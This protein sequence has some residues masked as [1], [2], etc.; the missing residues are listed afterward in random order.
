LLWTLA[1][2]CLASPRPALAQAGATAPAADS[3]DPD[4]T[5]VSFLPVAD[6]RVEEAH[7]DTNFG[8]STRLGTDGDA[9]YQ[10]ESALT[11]DVSGLASVVQSATLWLYVTSDGTADGPSVY[12]VSDNWSESGVTWTSRP[13]PTG[14]AASRMGAGAPNGWVELDVTSLIRGNGPVSLLLAQSSTDGA[15]YYSRQGTYKPMLVV[16][17]AD[18]V[19]LAAGDIACRPGQAVTATQCQQ[20]STSDLL[21]GSSSRSRVLAL[22]DEQYETGAYADFMAPGAYDS[23]W[24]RVKPITMPI[25]GNHEYDTPGA[26]GYYE[27][28]GSAAGDPT[29]GYYSFDLGAW[30]L[31]ALNSEIAASTG[32]AQETWLRSDL[33]G[34]TQPCIL[35]YWHQPRYTS[36]SVHKPDIYVT[37]LWQDLYAAGADLVLSGHNHN[38]ERFA[39]QDAAG[40]ADP[41][42][43]RQFV[44]GTGGESLY[45]FGTIQPN[46]EVHD[47]STFGVLALALRGSGYEWR[48]VPQAGGTFSDAGSAS[49]HD[50]A[51]AA[52]LAASPSV[53]RAP[54]AVTVD[55][56]AS[57]DTDRTPIAS[58]RFDFGDGSAPVGPQPD[59]TAAHTYTV[60]GSYTVTVT[61]ADRAGLV[62]RAS[63]P[64]VV[65][66]SNLVPNPGFETDLSGWN[67][68]G[69]GPG[70]ALTRAA[71]GHS[72]G[73]A[74]QLANTG[75]LPSTCGLNDSPNVVATT[76]AAPYTATLWV[77]ADTPGATLK[78]RWR[79]WSGGLLA[80]AATTLATLT[81]DWQPVSVTYSPTLPGASTLDLNAYVVG[82]APGTCFYGDDVSVTAP[83]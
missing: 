23:T 61:V 29:K 9:G 25:P 30:H 52:S 54:L 48:F 33:A 53:G 63:A 21:M 45:G 14:A 1:L 67:T 71:G 8:A 27:Y 70:I 41:R 38:Y 47:G 65:K 77:R 62:T 80:G 64:V 49:G 6:A 66:P 50:S 79:E 69:S 73:W 46:S 5:T 59:A 57:T 20:Q 22:G 37:P 17:S 55:A 7:P 56:S 18:P 76:S 26:A 10:I 60:P 82:A 34:T 13:Q 35:A 19:V 68:S 44:V 15:I 81:S 4:Q 32:S 43:I 74:A 24:G 28:F 3:V 11:F 58:Y 78:L 36:G 31:V 39:P 12:P 51:P 2:L 42:G 75:A 83:G 16:T 40:N 72:G